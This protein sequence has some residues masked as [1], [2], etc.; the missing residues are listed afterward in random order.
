V[1]LK[2]KEK[3]SGS[4]P[5]NPPEENLT[6]CDDLISKRGNPLPRY[7]NVEGEAGMR[8]LP[9]N[10]VMDFTRKAALTQRKQ[11]LKEDDLAYE[12]WLW[13]FAS[14]SDGLA[15]QRVVRRWHSEKKRYIKTKVNL[16]M[17]CTLLTGESWGKCKKTKAQYAVRTRASQFERTKKS[18]GKLQVIEGSRNPP[19]WTSDSLRHDP[20]KGYERRLRPPSV[21]EMVG[22]YTPRK[23]ATKVLLRP[24]KPWPM[25]TLVAELLRSYDSPAKACP[26]QVVRKPV[27]VKPA[28]VTP[29][30]ISRPLTAL[31]HAEMHILTD[32]KLLNAA[33]CRRTQESI[34]WEVAR[35]K[36]NA[37]GIVSA[38]E[39]HWENIPV[40]LSLLT[41]DLIGDCHEDY[42]SCYHDSWFNT[43]DLYR[44]CL[45]QQVGNH[46]VPTAAQTKVFNEKFPLSMGDENRYHA[47]WQAPVEDWDGFRYQATLIKGAVTGCR[48][49]T[50][51]PK[52]GTSSRAEYK[53][54][55]LDYGWY[56]GSINSRGAYELT[57]SRMVAVAQQVV[58]VGEPYGDP[59]RKKIPVSVVNHK[60]QG[61]PSP[62]GIM[63]SHFVDELNI[64][65]LPAMT[66]MEYV[67]SV[68]DIPNTV[69]EYLTVLDRQVSYVCQLA[70]KYGIA[71]NDPDINDQKDLD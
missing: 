68:R 66:E 15:P 27:E 47:L 37:E 34:D 69:D 60:L 57:R 23:V 61:V 17:V 13:S 39:K 26:M 31:V 63:S 56:N 70:L 35:F 45:Y 12:S 44:E 8:P 50:P 43:P 71:S 5:V 38:R 3:F 42:M 9:D 48:K 41:L 46:V 30:P 19:S 24:S 58:A 53:V 4:E 64:D 18:V 16:Q 62:L 10:V 14:L 40:D 22:E 28:A 25:Q 65:V 11:Q 36:R 49:S 54:K 21:V 20:V 29:S 1:L 33:A 52:R 32:S 6:I 2:P 59:K 67:N 51:K 55:L 7:Y